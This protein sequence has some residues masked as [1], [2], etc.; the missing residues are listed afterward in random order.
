MPHKLTLSLLLL[1]VTLPAYAWTHG[2]A[3]PAGLT[4]NLLWD[5][6]ALAA[7]QSFRDGCQDGANQLQAAI[8][9]VITVNIKVGADEINGNPLVGGNVGDGIDLCNIGGGCFKTYSAI[10]A[11]LPTGSADQISF[12]N[13]LPNANNLQGTTAFYVTSSV[14]KALG[15]ISP[16]AAAVDGA[17]GV[18]SG[19]SQVQMAGLCAHE[20]TH[21]M[22]REPSVAPWTFGR[23]TAASTWLLSGSCS[24]SYLSVDGGV[25]KFADYDTSADCSDFLI[26]G[27]QDPGGN[28]SYDAFDAFWGVQSLSTLST[29]D[30][31]QID[32]MGFNDH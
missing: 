13:A 30:N 3:P 1:L 22:G 25:T 11:A 8:K 18:A 29:V 32:I 6:S 23:F 20:L 28:V 2:A 26:N 10:Y 17:I 21:A 5:A 4:V 14:Q 19:F 7:A 12:K 9:N 24:A 31:R 16:T 27:V 15:F